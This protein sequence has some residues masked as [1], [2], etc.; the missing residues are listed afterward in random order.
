M[1]IA[2]FSTPV[3]LLT[4]LLAVAANRAHAENF[5]ARA[6]N[7]G[8]DE[9]SESHQLALLPNK[10]NATGLANKTGRLSA[11]NSIESNARISLHP[12]SDENGLAVTRPGL[13][14]MS[15]PFRPKS[16]EETVRQFH[17]EGLSIGRLWQSRSA[18]LNIGL[19]PKGKP[20]VWFVKKLP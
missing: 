17:K 13:A 15:V 12:N 20:G 10:F 16:I 5:A 9:S 8:A 11:F 6:A 14:N 3:S 4:L 19:N 1:R 2:I 18:D 7:T